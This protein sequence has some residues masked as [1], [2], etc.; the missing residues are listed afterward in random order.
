MNDT[1]SV[2]EWID[3]LTHIH[4]DLHW[5]LQQ[6]HQKFWCQVLFDESL[7]QCLDSYLRYAPRSFDHRIR[8]FGNALEKSKSVHRLVFMTFLRMATHKESQDHFI[9]P[10]AFGDI[11]YE[12]FIFDIPKLMDLCVLFG[13]NSALLTK[14]LTNIFT[15]QP[16]YE[17]DLN[18]IMPTLLQVFDDVKGKCGLLDGSGGT[19]KLISTPKQ[20]VRSLSTED[21]RDIIFY[22]SDIGLTFLAFLEIYPPACII[23]HQHSLVSRISTFY[24]MVIPEIET[25]LKHRKGD[26][27]SLYIL[28][29]SRLAQSKKALVKI[30]QTILFTCFLQPMLD[31]SGQDEVIAVCIEDYLQVISSVLS[32]KRFLCLYNEMHS[33]QEDIEMITQLTKN[34]DET[35]TQ[36]ILDAVQTAASM[37][38]KKK[39]VKKQPNIHQ[40]QT[41]TEKKPVEPTVI[42]EDF[43]CEPSNYPDYGEGACAASVSGIQLESYIS[44]VKDLLP[45]LGDGFII[46]CLEEYN[47]DAEKVINNLLEDKLPSS[48]QELDRSMTRESLKK[49]SDKENK[50]MLSERQNIY[51]NDEFDVFRR[52]QIDTS[53]IHQG[54]KSKNYKS[55]VDDRSEIQAMKSRYDKYDVIEDDAMYDDEYDDTYDDNDVGANDEDSADELTARRPFTIPR[56]LAGVGGTGSS[57]D[58]DDSPDDRQPYRPPRDQFVPNP[59]ELR[60]RQQ[61]RQH[62]S[63]YKGRDD[64]QVLKGQPKGKG[65]SGDTERKRRDKEKNKSA[66]ANHNRK[67]MADKKRSKAMGGMF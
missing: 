56:I 23:L 67:T 21:F 32:E 52:D 49:K 48:L 6:S 35:R 43:E 15:Q 13:G 44:A 55:A 36:F 27:P 12:N 63:K 19:P 64:K 3:I 38:G 9:S 61:D 58:N 2:E 42:P 16:K 59:A 17:D 20:T 18:D 26:H 37:Y 54:K 29:K 40:M 45:E 5:L 39:Y 11:I 50:S 65:Q 25:S 1:A 31:N 57:D 8:L 46:A 66:R 33:V 62:R 24:E 28:L 60:E 4:E 30:C 41:Q 34:I 7:H 51:D 10:S 47:Y 53:K 14:M 22:I